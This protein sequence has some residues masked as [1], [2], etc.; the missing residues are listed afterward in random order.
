MVGVSPDRVRVE[1]DGHP[2]DLTHLDRVL[3]PSGCTKAEVIDYYQGIADVLLPHLADRPLTMRRFPEGT[4]GQGF[5]AKNAPGGTPSW[6]RRSVQLMSDGDLDQVIADSCA[7]LVWLANLSSIE[8]HVPIWTVTP[9]TV[10]QRAGNLCDRFVVDL[11]PGK[12]VGVPECATLAL[13]LRGVLADDG[14]DALPKT[15]GGAGLHL[16]VPIAP[17]G[18]EA[19]VRYVHDLANALSTAAPQLA[20]A[21]IGEKERVGKVLLDWRQNVYRATTIA[22]YSLRAR[23]E[24]LVSTPVT[25]DEVG[26]ATEGKVLRFGPDE[27]RAR[28]ERHGD[29][30]APVLAPDRPPLPR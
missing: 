8:L 1:V 19:V 23:E 14:L 18:N 4:A 9:E 24:P 2:V 20:V 12:G 16:L 6:V 22:P 17:T 3:Y 7:T 10:Q 13:A 30:L 11:D 21:R 26:E 25:W 27:V 29:L 5:F 15:T 28:L